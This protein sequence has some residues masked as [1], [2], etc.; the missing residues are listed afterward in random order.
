M[1]QG[2]HEERARII[3]HL[4]VSHPGEVQAYSE[5]INQLNNQRQLPAPTSTVTGFTVTNLFPSP[6]HGYWWNDNVQP[7]KWEDEEIATIV[8]D[9]D[10]TLRDPGDI[11]ILEQQL[12][13]LKD[14]C[15]DRYQAAGRP[16]TLLWMVVQRI[17]RFD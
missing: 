9:Y 14:F 6:Y 15:L 2:L 13:N 5:I 10:L 16:Q 1:P 11:P 3:L 4:P 17:Q 7:P 12:R 8:I